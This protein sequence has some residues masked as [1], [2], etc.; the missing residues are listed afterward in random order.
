MKRRGTT[1]VEVMLACALAAAGVYVIFLLASE[2]LS[3]AAKVRGKN[4]RLMEARVAALRLRRECE[5]AIGASYGAEGL[6]LTRE[7]GQKFMW[8]VGAGDLA[9]LLL[10]HEAGRAATVED[11]VATHVEA[12]T[13]AASEKAITIAITAHGRKI[14]EVLQ[15]WGRTL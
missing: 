2:M 7:G 14:E 15:V 5:V 13:Y 6:F 4:E 10:R 12:L 1:L 11:A 3:A 8:Q 9:G